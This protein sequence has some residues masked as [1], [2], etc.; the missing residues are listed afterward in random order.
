MQDLKELPIINRLLSSKNPSIIYK[1]KVNILGENEKSSHITQLR[2]KIKHSEMVKEL[3]SHRKKDGTINTNPYK[4]WQGPHWTLAVLAELDYPQG[5]ASLNPL[6]DQFYDYL[7]SD[8][9]LKPP[10]SLIIPGQENRVRRCA[11]QEANA[12]WYSL[13]LGIEDERIEIFVN[14]LIEFQWPDGGWNCDKRPQAKISSFVESILPIRALYLYGKLKN[15][16]TSIETAK[17]TANFFLKR[18]LFRRKTDNS[19]INP[20]FLKLNYPYYVHY[21]ILLS[22][23]VMVEAGYIHDD[24]CQ[25]ALD[26]L[27]S[28]RLSDGSFPLEIKYYKYNS[29]MI[30]NGSLFNWGPVNKRQTNDFVTVD[31]LNILKEAGR[32]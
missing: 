19:I 32:L 8:K 9:H 11:S 25:E 4:K 7:L 23:K 5:D 28:K 14:R 27:E 2:E 15:N 31:A 18:K 6:R 30:T 12:V 10:R 3:L 29:H 22:L 13:K 1:A 16:K 26:L 24:R 17:R 21:T 20:R